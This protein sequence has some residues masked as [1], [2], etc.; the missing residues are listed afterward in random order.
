MSVKYDE[1]F[2]IAK[3]QLGIEARYKEF[4]LWSGGCVIGRTDTLEHARE[5]LTNYIESQLRAEL[6]GYEKRVTFI[7]SELQSLVLHPAGLLHFITAY[8]GKLND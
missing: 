6:A 4:V 3:H 8:G 2:R 7:K 1:A 5:L